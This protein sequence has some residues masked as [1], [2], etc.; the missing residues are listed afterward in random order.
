MSE[1][2]DPREARARAAAAAYRSHELP[3]P[4]PHVSVEVRAPVPPRQQSPKKPRDARP[5]P[6]V[7]MHG[8]QAPFGTAFLVALGWSAGRAVFRLV[9]VAILFAVLGLMLWRMLG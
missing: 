7:V 8:V 1:P 4:T 5:A 6:R 3:P 2:E 9:A